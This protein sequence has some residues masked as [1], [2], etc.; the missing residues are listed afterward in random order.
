MTEGGR[1]D[2]LVSSTRW[3]Q[4]LRQAFQRLSAEQRAVLE[5]SDAPKEKLGRCIYNIAAMSPTA[6][7]IADAVRARVPGVELTFK[8]DPRRQAILD[9][10]PQVP[11]SELPWKHALCRELG[12][13]VTTFWP[14]LRNA[15][16]SYA[17]LDPV[18]VGAVEQMIDFVSES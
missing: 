11:R 10:W 18:L 2:V 15:V 13:D 16:K 14:R 17:D 5:L 4:A 9:S 3:H 1:P 6:D 7:E 12:V 8:S